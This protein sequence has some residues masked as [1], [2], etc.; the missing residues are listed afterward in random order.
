MN[1]LTHANAGRAVLLLPL[2]RAP[3]L[4][5]L[6]YLIAL[7]LVA[8]GIGTSEHVMIGLLPNVAADFGVSIDVAGLLISAYALG[9]ALGAPVMVSTLNQGAF[10]LGNATGA[11]LGSTVLAAGPPDL[12][13]L[14]IRNFGGFSAFA[15]HMGHPLLWPPPRQA[16]LKL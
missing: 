11:W 6:I 2:L 15:R 5:H 16:Q 10:N 9:V 8:F 7:A 14:S 4:C 3:L 13:A 1:S 12:L